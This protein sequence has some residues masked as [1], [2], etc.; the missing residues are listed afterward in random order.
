[1]NAMSVR[2]TTAAVVL[3]PAT[4]GDA[5]RLL[6]WRNDPSAYQYYRASEPVTWETHVAW[7]TAVLTDP[8]RALYIATADDEPVG[9]V[10]LDRADDVVEVTMAIAAASRGRGFGRGALACALVTS[11][12]RFPDAR[13]IIAEIAE[14][15]VAS[16]VLF[17]SFGFRE[18]A[19]RGRFIVVA[20][21]IESIPPK[22]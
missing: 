9:Q 22:T 21:S 13:M 7:L 12:L 8:D 3:R 15:N 17:R 16:L 20:S 18:A 10:R 2:T 11:R 6:T 1:M 14:G 5:N 19:R 4:I